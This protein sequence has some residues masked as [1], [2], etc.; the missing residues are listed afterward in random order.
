MCVYLLIPVGCTV[1][2]ALASAIPIS[3]VVIG[4]FDLLH[5]M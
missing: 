5:F 1:T 4:T 3:M 2:V